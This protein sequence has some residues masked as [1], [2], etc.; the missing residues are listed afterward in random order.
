MKRL[1]ATGAVL[2]GLWMVA[3]AIFEWPPLWHYAGDGL[4]S[5]MNNLRQID[6]MKEEWALE[7]NHTNGAPVDPAEL[8]RY[9]AGRGVRWGMPH[10]PSGGTYTYGRIGQDP[11]CSIGT[12]TPPAPL[13]E[14]IGLFGWRWKIPPS[15]A[16]SH[17]LPR[18]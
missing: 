13:K 18:R 9:F 4:N 10:C 1:F 6:G 12:N 7:T 17:A 3:S 15:Q 8:E 14:H 11:V 5:C 16:G 2:V